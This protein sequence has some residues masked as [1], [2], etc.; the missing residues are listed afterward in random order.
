M[1]AR[2][3]SCL[4]IAFAAVW[5]IGPIPAASGIPANF[6]VETIERS[7]TVQGRPALWVKNADGRIRVTAGNQP[8]VQIRAIK[9]V[10]GAS[11]ADDARQYAARVEVR[12][13]QTGNRIQAEAIYPATN[14]FSFGRQPEPL[15]H[16][17]ITAP[18]GSDLEAINADGDLQVDGLDGKIKVETADGKLSVINCS[19]RI[20]SRTGDGDLR[21]ER[22]RGEVSAKTGDGS[23]TLDGVLEALDTTSGD[24]RIRIKVLTGSKM[25]RDWSIRTGDGN[26]QLSLPES[27]AADLDVSTGDGQIRV[28]YP[29]TVSKS[30]SEHKLAGK[31]NAGGKLLHIQTGDGD[32]TIEKQ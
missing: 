30:K 31:L 14:R 10:H 24:G 12:I 23:I 21:I 27:F 18:K 32:I 7:F 20:E 15:V 25:M 29:V 16:F 3:Q 13:E 4:C 5:M 28:D 1:S 26:I 17:E 2:W 9:E 8:Q 6:V 19:G 11:S 22:A